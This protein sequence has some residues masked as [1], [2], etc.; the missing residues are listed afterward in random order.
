MFES[1][2]LLCCGLAPNAQPLIAGVQRLVIERPTIYPGR[3]K[4]R[5]RDIITLALRA[6]QWAGI[7]KRA[8]N[9]EAEYVE[10]FAWKG[11]VRKD[12]HHARI[13]ATLLPGERLMVEEGCKGVAA[14]KRHNVLDAVGLG[15]FAVGRRA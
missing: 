7:V 11:T 3:Q 8:T 6:G 5:P 14:S 13:Q 4:A 15:L 10:P 9:I 12:I 1:N 2:Q